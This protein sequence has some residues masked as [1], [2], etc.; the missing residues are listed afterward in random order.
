MA[1]YCKRLL[2][3]CAAGVLFSLSACATVKKPAVSLKQQYH[4]AK[5]AFHHKKY[6]QAFQQ[7]QAPAKAGN[8]NAQYA[9]GYMYYYG[10]GTKTDITKAKHW[11]QQA[12]QQHQKQAQHALKNLQ[13]LEQQRQ[14]F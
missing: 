14:T 6:H 5:Q 3:L 13:M 7:I 11:F 10:H 4:Q 2:L 12:A 9:L 1:L 8:A